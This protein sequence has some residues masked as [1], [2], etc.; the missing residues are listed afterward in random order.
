MRSLVTSHTR[1]VGATVTA[2]AAVQTWTS[3]RPLS[4]CS[5]PCACSFVCVSLSA[6]SHDACVEGFVVTRL[7]Q[8]LAQDLEAS[9][10][11]RRAWAEC[12]EQ[13]LAM[14]WAGTWMARVS[15]GQHSKD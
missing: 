2:A 12:L 1:M 3:Y 6:R 5:C 9:W 4:D 15:M 11:M 7:T 14:R 8:C 13:S 10:A